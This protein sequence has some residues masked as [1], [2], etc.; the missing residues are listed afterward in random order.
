MSDY[1]SRENTVRQICKIAEQLPEDKR[2]PYV[3]TALYIQDNKEMFP[4]ADV[5]EIPDNATNGDIIKTIFNVTKCYDV[6][7]LYVADGMVFD[8]HWWNAPYQ[9]GGE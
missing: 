5:R 4:S 9:K 3:M 2:S 8:K 6:Q 7:N 1:I